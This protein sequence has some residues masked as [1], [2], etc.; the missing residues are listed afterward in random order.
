MYSVPKG[1]IR[2]IR[3]DEFESDFGGFIPELRDWVETKC[4]NG[5]NKT[6]LNCEKKLQDELAL[7]AYG[8][9]IG[10]GRR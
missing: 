4:G 5:S 7:R 9:A 10:S 3:N 1:K 2:W 6:Q 8:D